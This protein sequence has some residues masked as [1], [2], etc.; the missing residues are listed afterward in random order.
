LTEPEQITAALDRLIEQERSRLRGGPEETIREL[1]GKLKALARRRNAYQDQQ[2]A[3]YMTLEELGLKLR[4]LEEARD[5]VERELE[6]CTNRGERVRYL[7]GL[8]T[9]FTGEW[10][11]YCV[12]EKPTE[13]EN[14]RF[15]GVTLEA[16]EEWRDEGREVLATFWKENGQKAW[17]RAERAKL[18]EY[19]PEE[20]H[21]RYQELELRVIAHSKEELEIS[22]VCF[23][24][25]RIYICETSN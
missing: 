15:N 18:E 7:E 8:R 23:G 9:M 1:R 5:A 6:A 10:V 3:G 22:G 11:Q 20:R 4:E 17:A 21:E 2:A 19:T 13:P 25:E 24:P 12:G 16:I 14:M